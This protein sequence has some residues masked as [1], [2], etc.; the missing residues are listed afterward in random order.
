M[1]SPHKPAGAPPAGTSFAS[2]GRF[3]IRP[4]AGASP[5]SPWPA[6]APSHC[7][8]SGEV[9]ESS[10]LVTELPEVYGYQSLNLEIDGYSYVRVV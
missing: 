9:G 7:Y 8:F 1:C 5:A 6:A 2:D 3:L 10:Y 4:P